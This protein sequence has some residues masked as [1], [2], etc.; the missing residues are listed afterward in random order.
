MTFEDFKTPFRE[1]SIDETDYSFAVLETPTDF[2][3]KLIE[4][5]QNA[6]NEIVLSALYL[7]SKAREVALLDELAKVL[8]EKPNLKV[9]LIFDHSRSHRD[10]KSLKLLTG[11]LGKFPGR[12]QVLLYEMPQL[13]S[14]PFSL[15]PVQLKEVAAV[16]HCKFMICDKKVI[17]TGSNLSEEYFV[18]RQDRYWLIEDRSKNGMLSFLSKF[19][20]IVSKDC[21]SLQSNGRC[22]P[23][24]DS[25]HSLRPNIE[26]LFKQNSTMNQIG[27]DKVQCI[28]ITQHNFHG[29]RYEEDALIALMKNL[30]EDAASYSITLSTPYTNFSGVLSEKIMETCFSG[31]K[32]EIIGPDDASHGFASATG[33]K[34]LIPEFHFTAFH[35]SLRGAFRKLKKIQFPNFNPVGRSF[36]ENLEHQVFQKPGWTFHAKGNEVF[37]CVVFTRLDKCKLLL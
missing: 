4:L 28:P 2:Y 34:S 25:T 26:N 22:D 6:E 13:R 24:V 11:L 15:L 35:S 3:Q 37:L 36:Y 12:I 17:L 5:I 8:S 9:K 23:P 21:H 18:T 1:I 10:P 27:D 32:I 16:Y 31:D 19:V 14:L 29:I 30:R 20:D 33:F 7:G